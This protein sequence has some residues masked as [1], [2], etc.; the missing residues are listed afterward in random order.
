MPWFY[1][2]LSNAPSLW[3]CYAAALSHIYISQ[4]SF[5]PCQDTDAQV[6]SSFIFSCCPF[7]SRPSDLLD[8]HS[9]G[10]TQLRYLQV[11]LVRSAT[12]A[13][14]M[15]SWQWSVKNWDIMKW[16][17]LNI[18]IRSLQ[19]ALLTV[20]YFPIES[21]D[22]FWFWP[23]FPTETIPCNQ[24]CL[25][26]RNLLVNFNRICQDRGPKDV[27]LFHLSWKLKESNFT[28]DPLGEGK[29]LHCLV[30]GCWPVSTCVRLDGQQRGYHP[31]AWAHPASD[32]VVGKEA[33]IRL[34]SSQQLV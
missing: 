10:S 7:P 28:V 19:A 27:R 23:G 4:R 18:K 13:R 16:V 8:S 9:L 22:I 15:G 30:G 26:H 33:L 21:I 1:G 29:P 12:T 25:P 5:V 17:D 20:I 32:L 6:G 24:S 3:P 31:W 2:C 11:D 14:Q 34:W